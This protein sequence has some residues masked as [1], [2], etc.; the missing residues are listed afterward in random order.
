MAI[1]PGEYTDGELWFQ[2]RSVVSSV[3]NNA[4]FNCNGGKMLITARGWSQRDRFLALVRK[5]FGALPPR[6]AYYP[7]ARERYAALTG[8]RPR[9]QAFGEGGGPETLPWTLIE[10]V[11][12]SRADDPLFSV[13]PFC[14]ILSQTELDAPDPAGF[15]AASTAFCNDRLWGTLNAA[16][17]VSRATE[18]DPAVAAAIERAILELRYGTVAVNIWPAVAYATVS[19]P[20]GGH[21]S[22][23]PANIQ[24]GLGWVHNTFMLEGIEKSVIR[25]PSTLSPKPAW[26]CDN[27][28]ALTIGRRLAGFQMH[29]HVWSLPGLVAPSLRG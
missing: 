3:S 17:V 11:D 23:T 9:V 22:A 13:E 7:G 14:S 18:R 25:S 5:A 27:R 21:P 8:G 24:S 15:L 16:L 12:S 28:M 4:S 6:R 19:P 1:V 29:P 10:D 20:W 26:Y 2:A